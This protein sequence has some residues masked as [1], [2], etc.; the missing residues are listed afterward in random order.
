[1]RDDKIVTKI[2]NGDGAAVNEA[3]NKYSRLVWHI[4]STVLRNAVPVEDIEECVA[5]VFVYLWQNHDKYDAERGKL[6]SW[7]SAVA[8]SK[9]IDKYRRI[10]KINDAPLDDEIP[11]PDM[12]IAEGIIS[13]ETKRELT[14]AINLLGEPDR[15]II[16]RRYYYGQ[17]PREIGLVLSIP[18]KQ[19]ENRLY[20][21]KLKL[22]EIISCE[23][24]G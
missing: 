13:T 23:K 6:K 2:K 9:A 19:V 18:V 7:L 12:G 15:E 8:K 21:S 5:D 10:S 1:M 14:A 11:A 17:K 16:I 22:R 24:G 20:R 3:M 4:A